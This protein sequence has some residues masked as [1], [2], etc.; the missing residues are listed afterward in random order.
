MTATDGHT[1]AALDVR[2]IVIPQGATESATWPPVWEYAEGTVLG[3]PT[4]WPGSWTARMEIRDYRGEGGS[5]LAVLHSVDPDADGTLTLTSHTD[6]GTTYARVT[7][8]IPAD[9]SAAWTWQDNDAA[10]YDLELTN[11]PR[12]IRLAEGPATLSGEVTTVA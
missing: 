3:V 6:G 7:A 2:P 9:T 4:G 5:V 8:A 10:V 11:G 1:T 12:T